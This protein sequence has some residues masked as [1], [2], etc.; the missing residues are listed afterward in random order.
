MNLGG[1]S[2]H[3][4]APDI[5]FRRVWTELKT[6]YVYMLVDVENTFDEGK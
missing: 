1:N 2:A 3:K 4:T 6:R 5:D